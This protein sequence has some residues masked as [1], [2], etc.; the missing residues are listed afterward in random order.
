MDIML[1]YNSKIGESENIDVSD[2]DFEDHT[3]EGIVLKDKYVYAK[4]TA[5]VN[6]H[7]LSELKPFV[8]NKKF[9][10]QT[11]VVLRS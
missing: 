2:I 1:K 10:W 7:K 6:V 4:V 9:Q 5:N 3:P 11:K 8:R